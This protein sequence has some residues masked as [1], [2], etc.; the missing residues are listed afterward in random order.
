MSHLINE[1]PGMSS[2]DHLCLTLPP[3]PSWLTSQARTRTSPWS[4]CTIATGMSTE[5]LTCCWRVAQTLWVLALCEASAP[6]GPDSGEIT[7][8]LAQITVI[9]DFR[10]FEGYGPRDVFIWY[11]KDRGSFPYLG[12]GTRKCKCK[13]GMHLPN[14]RSRPQ[15]IVIMETW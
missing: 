3:F 7:A 2:K 5:P 4:H 12:K 15:G 9:L 1:M 6:W 8:P 11:S 10:Q 13:V 14:V